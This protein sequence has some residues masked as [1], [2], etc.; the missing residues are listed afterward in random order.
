MLVSG[1][2]G[3]GDVGDEKWR[4]NEPYKL[5][6]ALITITII[7]ITSPLP[8]TITATSI[9][10]TTTASNQAGRNTQALQTAPLLY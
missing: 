2:G 3:G 10:T 5:S 1:G 6:Q 4:P 7:N 9:A 8:P